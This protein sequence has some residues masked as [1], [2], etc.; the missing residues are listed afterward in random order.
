MSPA[1]LIALAVI[2]GV[3]ALAVVVTILMVARRLQRLMGDLQRIDQELV[4]QLEQL[5]RDAEVTGR[6]LERVSE[7]ADRIAG[8]GQGPSSV[9]E[10]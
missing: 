9:R 10:R 7:S 6:E 4:P 3:S 5:R 8:D 1:V 2:A